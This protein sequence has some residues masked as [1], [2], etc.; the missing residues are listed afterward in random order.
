MKFLV[1]LDLSESTD[2]IVQKV[3]EIAKA[4]SAKVWLLH[5]ADP[6]PDFV[7]WDAGPQ[8]GGDGRP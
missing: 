5:V 6:D 2:K 3:E 7:G 4:L 1:G 8:S